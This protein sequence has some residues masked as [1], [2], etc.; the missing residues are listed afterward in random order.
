MT[1]MA[2]PNANL[3]QKYSGSN[4]KAAVLVL[5]LGLAFVFAYA[6]ISAFQTPAAWISY[7]PHFITGVL[8]GNTPLHLLSVLQLLLAVWLVVGKFVKMAAVVAALF[9]LGVI[10]PNFASMLIVFRDVGLLCMAV[11][12][13]LVA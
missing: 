3:F 2:N 11:A 1:L 7:L 10:L 6:A 9:L 8:S 12:L 13:F 4:P 5:R